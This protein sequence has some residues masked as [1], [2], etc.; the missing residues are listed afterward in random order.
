LS[1]L[2]SIF[3]LFAV[4]I[5]HQSRKFRKVLPHVLSAISDFDVALFQ[6]NSSI[7]QVLMSSQAGISGLDDV[8]TIRFALFRCCLLQHWSFFMGSKKMNQPC[9]PMGFK[10]FQSS[11]NEIL[12]VFNQTNSDSSSSGDRGGG[13][14]GVSLIRVQYNLATLRELHRVHNLFTVC[15]PELRIQCLTVCLNMIASTSMEL[16]RDEIVVLIHTIASF[17]FR[18]FFNVFVPQ[19]V[20]NTFPGNSV[21]NFQKEKLCAQFAQDA[22]AISF[23][24]N[25]YNFTNYLKTLKEMQKK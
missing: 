22:D 24:E 17:H 23:A 9:D 3:Q 21:T 16:L 6:S 8:I 14:G 19:Y 1:L 18:D 13:G 15:P 12:N 11:M 7:R 4:A 5:D 2:V 25:A 20:A 10:F